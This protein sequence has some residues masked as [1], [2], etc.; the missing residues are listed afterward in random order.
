MVP[1]RWHL[2]HEAPAISFCP[3]SSRRP[4][5]QEK[6]HPPKLYW[7]WLSKGMSFCLYSGSKRTAATKPIPVSVTFSQLTFMERHHPRSQ[8]RVSSLKLETKPWSFVWLPRTS[9][10]PCSQTKKEVSRQSRPILA[11]M[12]YLPGHICIRDDR[13]VGGLGDKRWGKGQGTRP[14]LRW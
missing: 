1:G 7:C 4:H 13:G 14:E 6:F 11:Q 5:V 9:T 3:S 10:S 12:K 2:Q 8:P